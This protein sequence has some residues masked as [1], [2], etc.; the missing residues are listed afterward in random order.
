M[1]HI[2]SGW[3]SDPTPQSSLKRMLAAVEVQDV[4][5][6]CLQYL[7]TDD[8]RCLS[9]VLC[10]D[11]FLEPPTDVTQAWTRMLVNFGDGMHAGAGL[12][13]HCEMR[14]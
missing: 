6:R 11:C 5:C 4:C 14:M 10:E 13:S 9:Y 1:N 8:G 12:A 2:C 7:T 3:S